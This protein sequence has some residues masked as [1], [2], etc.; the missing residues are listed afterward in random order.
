MLDEERRKSMIDEGRIKELE[1][2]IAEKI[3]HAN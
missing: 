3:K 1:G 2:V